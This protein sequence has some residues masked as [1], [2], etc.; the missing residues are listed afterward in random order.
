MQSLNAFSFQNMF[1]ADHSVFVSM[2]VCVCVCVCACSSDLYWKRTF[3]RA[4]DQLGAVIVKCV[5]PSVVLQ[6]IL[7]ADYI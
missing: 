4:L 7:F 6:N 2:C 3:G 1:R 5:Y